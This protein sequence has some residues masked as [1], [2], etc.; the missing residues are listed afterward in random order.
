[1]RRFCKK[2]SIPYVNVAQAKKALFADSKLKSFDFVVYSKQ[3]P[4]LLVDL[5]GRRCHRVNSA[6]RAGRRGFRPGPANTDVADLAHVGAGLRR[7]VQR[8]D[9][10]YLLAGSAQD[11]AVSGVVSAPASAGT[12]SWAWNLA[13]YRSRMRRRSPKWETVSL[14]VKDFRSLARPLENWL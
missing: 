9:D 10:V 4:N 2:R 13:E 12:C 7:G 3:G 11:G 5:N 6:G 14:P 8:P 1:L